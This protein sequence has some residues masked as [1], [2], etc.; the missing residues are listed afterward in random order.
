MKKKIPAVIAL[1]LLVPLAALFFSCGSLSGSQIANILIK[2]AP[3][4]MKAL[5]DITPE[6]EYYIGRAVAA[7]I[8]TMYN[9]YDKDWNLIL[10][11]N[12]ICKTITVNSDRPEIY[13][14][15]HVAILDTDEI[16]AFA[17][18]GGHIFITRGLIADAPSEDALAGV[19]AHEVAHIQLQHGL[20]AIKNA[21]A[22]QALV[23]TGTAVASEKMNLGELTDAFTQSIGDIVNTM[24]VSGYSQ[25]QEFDAD[26]KALGLMAAAGY[27]PQGLVLMLQNLAKNYTPSSGFGKTH[28]NP[29]DRL[30]NVEK[31]INNYNVAD[32]TSYRQQRY[33]A[34]VK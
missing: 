24:V 33:S 20:K 5:E 9:I 12:K 1:V 25:S 30:K 22:T 8:L 2:S 31:T 19:I 29:N 26:N 4:I 16:N 11:L 14:G 27:D 3:S 21:R 6:Q 15:Y 34:T 28:P 10:Y 7:N 32:T 17:T 23:Q 18:S 13:N